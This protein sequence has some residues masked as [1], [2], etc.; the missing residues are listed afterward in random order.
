MNGPETEER[1]LGESE[2]E[3]GAAG[4]A[5]GA[6]GGESSAEDEAAGLRAALAAKESE[7][8]EYLDLLRR[9]KADFD[10][11]RR[12]SEKE[13]ERAREAGAAE[14]ARSLL[15][16]VDNLERAAEVEG[17]EEALREGVRMTLRQLKDALARAGVERIEALGRPFDP[18]WHEALQSVPAGELAPG[19]VARVFEEGYKMGDRL[20]RPARVAVA[21]EGGP[22]GPEPEPGPLG[23]GDDDG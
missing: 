13:L 12:R 7:A 4:P 17:G 21:V 22:P 8:A 23:K 9:V 10:N 20:L 19:T 6:E 3:E 5:G 1:E 18:A 2:A 15:S 14:L 16:V 11:F